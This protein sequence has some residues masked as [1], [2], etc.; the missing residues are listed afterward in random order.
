MGKVLIHANILMDCVSNVKARHSALPV[1]KG[2]KWVLT[3]FVRIKEYNYD[4]M[5]W[6]DTSEQYSFKK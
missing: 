1:I 2:E 5:S 6:R 4:I 3:T